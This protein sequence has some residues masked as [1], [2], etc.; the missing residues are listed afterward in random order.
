VRVRRLLALSSFPDMHSDI[1]IYAEDAMA[2]LVLL[3]FHKAQRL[4][5]SMDA[6]HFG[7]RLV[8]QKVLQ[9]APCSVGVVVDRG[10]GKQEQAVVVVFIGGADD[11]EPARRRGGG[12]GAGGG[13]DAGGRQVLRGVLPE[14]RGGRRQGHG[15]PGEA[16]GGRRGAGGGATRPTVGEL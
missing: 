10:L 15:V 2:A 9:L 16:R 11:R 8:N 12:A 3:P 4:D 13:A 14:A 1:C 6:G 7:F 5:G